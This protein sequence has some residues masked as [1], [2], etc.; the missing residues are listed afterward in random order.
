[1][2]NNNENTV[3]VLENI[4]NQDTE[5]EVVE[6]YVDFIEFSDSN[7]VRMDMNL[8]EYPLFSKN[9][10]RKKN[11][12]I[13]YIFN[14]K[15]TKY[16][17][18]SP[19]VDDVTPGELEQ[20]V[21][22][23]L[24]KVMRNKGYKQKFVTTAR[25]I[26]N[27]MDISE[28]SKKKLYSS[29]KEALYRLGSTTYTFNN[30]LYSSKNKNILNTKTITKILE[31]TSIERKNTNNTDEIFDEEVK[32][33]FSDKRIKEV[34]II[35]IGDYFYEN[36]IDKGY[37][38]YNAAELL[39]IKNS[40][41]LSLYLL[42]TKMRFNELYL[43]IN[44]IRIAMRVGL[45]INPKNYVRTLTSIEKAC[46]NL[47]DKELIKDFKFTKTLDWQTSY[48][49]FFFSEEH[50]KI[51]QDNFYEDRKIFGDLFVSQ[52]ED[53]NK[54][55]AAN[56]IIPEGKILEYHE[57]TEEDIL[58]VYNLLQYSLKRLNTIK[59]IIKESINKYGLERVAQAAIYTKK[60][61]KLKPLEFFKKSIEFNYGV[62]IV[63]D[64]SK[65]IVKES[66]KQENISVT[67]AYDKFMEFDRD[68]QEKLIKKAIDEKI[69]VGVPSFLTERIAEKTRERIRKDFLSN[70]PKNIGEWLLEKDFFNKNQENKTEST[71]E[72]V[73]LINKND[74]KQEE[75]ILA[76]KKDYITDRKEIANYINDAIDIYSEILNFTEESIKSLKKDLSFSI[77]P[78]AIKGTLTKS[79]IDKLIE[80]KIKEY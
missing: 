68:Y 20:T 59:R 58:Y 55:D 17:E 19:M 4:D 31:I 35:V 74:L 66:K 41:S 33:Y 22:I 16:I 79:E 71:K 45:T 69:K 26:L 21:F 3:S 70:I 77:V 67:V 11:T 44:F 39:G 7:L 75:N 73:S 15:R 47:K 27:N 72:I 78:L 80:E 63:L 28:N 53:K 52:I 13:V 36:L 18:I 25:E 8:I 6:Q 43:K 2:E 42:L 60:N 34:F 23:A 29:V 9:K 65:E 38:V 24:T 50:N 30:T 64:K 76:E 54:L 5:I 37:L 10:R 57:V 61:A 56:L 1:M 62:N 46:Q 12:K 14:N 49:E 32:G 40:T 48:I 51:K